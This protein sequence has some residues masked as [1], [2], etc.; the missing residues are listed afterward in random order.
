ML[1]FAKGLHETHT[2]VKYV[3]HVN[4]TGRLYVALFCRR[5][6]RNAHIRKPSPFGFYNIK[7]RQKFYVDPLRSTWMER[8]GETLYRG[9]T[10]KRHVQIRGTFVTPQ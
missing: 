5:P 9:P 10:S 8:D 2:Y 7:S 1:F 6:T 4:G 3:N